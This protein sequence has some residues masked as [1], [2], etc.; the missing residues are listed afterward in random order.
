MVVITLDPGL[1]N[2]GYAIG[3]KPNQL[4]EYGTLY[5]KANRATF[6]ERKT[7]LLDNLYSKIDTYKV[8]LVVLEQFRVYEQNRAIHTTVEL[9][10]ALKEGLRLNFPKVQWEEIH[11]NSWNARWVHLIQAGAL[12]TVDEVWRKASEEYGS[13][14][15]RD[16]VKMLFT[17]VYSFKDTVLK[18]KQKEVDNS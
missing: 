16:A 1:A 8:N 12:F 11:H 6:E 4:I 15:S 5:T 14:H 13:E 18:K 9:I 3:K 7:Y 17:Y 2:F 10:G